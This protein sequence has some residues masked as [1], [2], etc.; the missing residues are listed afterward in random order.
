MIG[1]NNERLS[2]SVNA[3]LWPA[4]TATEDMA[5]KAFT[6]KLLGTQT[7]GVPGFKDEFPQSRKVLGGTRF[8]VNPQKSFSS[9]MPTWL[10]IR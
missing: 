1:K 7:M 3:H 2:Y 6:E 4:A 10:F 5:N 9:G 8:R